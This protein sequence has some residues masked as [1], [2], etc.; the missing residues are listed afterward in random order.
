[1]SAQIRFI[2]VSFSYPNSPEEIFRNLSFTLGAGWSGVVGTNGAGKSTLLRLAQGELLPTSGIVEPPGPALYAPQLA[3]APPEEMEEFMNDWDPPAV[4]LKE[5]LQIDYEWLFRWDTLSQGERKRLQLALVLRKDPPLLAVDEPTNHLDRRNRELI[6]QGLAA[7]EGVGLLVSHDRPLLDALTQR[8]LVVHQGGA[9]LRPGSFSSARDEEEREREELRRERGE[10]QRRNRKLLKEYRRRA[11]EAQKRSKGFSKAGLARR[12]SDGRAAVDLARI[13]GKD[14]RAGELKRQL[15]K[16]LADS[17]QRIEELQVPPAVLTGEAGLIME[18]SSLR[19]DRLFAL[20]PGEIP[21]GT[22][23]RLLHPEL[24]MEPGSRV[25]LAGPNGSGKSTLLRKIVAAVGEEEVPM[26]YLP[27]EL[28]PADRA[29]LFGAFA[30]LT[31]EERG[32]VLATIH[33]LGSDPQ[34]VRDVT[35]WSPGEERKLHFALGALRRPALLVLD[36]PTN[37]LDLPA[38]VALEGA[39]R[40]VSAAVLLVSHE[41]RFAAAVTDE[42]WMIEEEGTTGRL[43]SADQ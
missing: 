21:L 17:R 28:R 29:T 38:V 25:H 24:T 37:H 34:R 2:N 5:R 4:E 35:G 27:Q 1:M 23:R 31:S 8:T 13:T 36:E 42:R 7:Y 33:R 41:E 19:R 3:E 11:G 30:A 18:G 14:K 6:L 10:T 39:L 43:V 22:D 16:R 15:H 26:L 9:I 12:D 20:P 40:E 32:R